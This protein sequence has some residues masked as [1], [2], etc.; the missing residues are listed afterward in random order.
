MRLKL[1]NGPLKRWFFAARAEKHLGFFAPKV[2]VSDKSVSFS[3]QLLHWC[4]TRNRLKMNRALVCADRLYFIFRKLKM[5]LGRVRQPVSSR[6]KA[7][8]DGRV[9][10]AAGRKGRHQ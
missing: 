2:E 10:W 6:L 8:Q 4:N 3:R 7:G 9:D 5:I 1:A